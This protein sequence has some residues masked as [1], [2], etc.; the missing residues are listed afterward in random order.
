MGKRQRQMTGAFPTARGSASRQAP[1]LRDFA[2]PVREIWNAPFD[3][4]WGALPPVLGAEGLIVGGY[5]SRL[6]VMDSATRQVVWRQAGAHARLLHDGCVIADGGEDV[7]IFELRTGELLRVLRI[8]QLRWCVIENRVLVAVCENVEYDETTIAAYDWNSAQCLW[9]ASLGSGVH[10]RSLAALGDV[11]SYQWAGYGKSSAITVVRNLRTG[12]ERWSRHDLPALLDGALHALTDHG[13]IAQ[14]ETL[15]CIDLASG[16]NRW[17]VKSATGAPYVY[18]GRIYQSGW[19]SY[20]VT[21]V[22][23]G[24]SVIAAN[25]T[26]R[27]PK[28]LRNVQLRDIALVSE[29]HVF[30]GSETGG[31]FAFTRDMGEYVSNFQLPGASKVTTELVCIN[32]RAYHTSGYQRLS[33]LESRA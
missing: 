25:L 32:G 11:V 7:R 23:S 30:V 31:L 29:T 16:K 14:A 28:S 2:A 13:L 26:D 3:S 1:G 10:C 12:E 19:G 21:D 5:K 27:L 33:C 6:V 4:G 9:S 24:R 22:K 17:S 8:G 20:R 15:A 18:G